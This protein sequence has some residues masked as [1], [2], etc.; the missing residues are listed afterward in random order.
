MKSAYWAWGAV[1]ADFGVFMGPL[2]HST[3]TAAF[4]QVWVLHAASCA[5]LAT[6]S[7]VFMPAKDRRTLH[8]TWLLLFCFAMIAP[9]LGSLSILLIA[10]TTL[11][12][13]LDNHNH[14]K[15]QS[16]A[17][18]EFEV[19]SQQVGR[20]GQG[21]IRS[22]LT[23]HVPSD[24]R[25]RSLLTLQAVPSRV[26][27]PI[28]EDLLGDDTDDV[29]LIAFGMLDAEEKKLSV[30]IHR[31]QKN[32]ENPLSTRARYDCLRHLAELHLELIYAG[33]AHGGLKTHNLNQ[34]WKYLEMALA[35]DEQHESGIYFLKGR[36]LLAQGEME[37]ARDALTHA[38]Q[39]GQ[40]PS[41]VLP[42]LA[43]L[44]F[45]QREFGTVQSHM[46]A[47]ARLQVASRTSAVVDLWT[48]RDSVLRF[49]DRRILQHI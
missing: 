20:A 38:M 43:E 31:E 46:Q 8:W 1:A 2:P 49:R 24:V 29:R 9:V 12:K 48:G 6:S 23:T 15:P 44:A 14:A 10:H 3:S 42:Y 26:A 21:S 19:R 7:L 41:S 45:A 35:M 30:H 18:P 28:L 33:L 37:Q 34:A 32:L 22:R 27:N 36:V 16:V 17:L 40:S 11:R 25:M 5:V 39:L 4:V 47:L 13:A